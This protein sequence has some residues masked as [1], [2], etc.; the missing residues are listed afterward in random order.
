MVDSWTPHHIVTLACHGLAAAGDL[1]AELA[2]DQ[3]HQ[4]GSLVVGRPVGT[5]V[6]RRVVG[7]LDFYVLRGADALRWVDEVTDQPTAGVRRVIVGVASRPTV[8]HW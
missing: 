8:D 5:L 6:A 7:P 4:R 1:Y 2:S 3:H